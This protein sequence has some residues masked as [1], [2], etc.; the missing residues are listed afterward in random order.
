LL[1]S[2]ACLSLSHQRVF[3]RG[4]RKKHK[5]QKTH[6]HVF[7]WGVG[8]GSLANPLEKSDGQ[9]GSSNSNSN[10]QQQQH[11]TAATATNMRQLPGEFSF[12]DGVASQFACISVTLGIAIYDKR[13]YGLHIG[14]TITDIFIE[15]P[16][17][18]TQWLMACHLSQKNIKSKNK[19]CVFGFDYW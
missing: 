16:Q 10:I 12:V 15:N 14:G 6:C 4:A 8:N 3:A 13:I 18:H 9:R 11:P 19:V 2:T 17:H 1:F 7:L 5:T